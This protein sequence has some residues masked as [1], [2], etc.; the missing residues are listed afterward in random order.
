MSHCKI[1]RVKGFRRFPAEKLHYILFGY[2]V[3]LYIN[4]YFKKTN[5]K[6]AITRFTRHVGVVEYTCN[7]KN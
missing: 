3:V 2:S 1:G 5:E 4:S 6:F 7:Y